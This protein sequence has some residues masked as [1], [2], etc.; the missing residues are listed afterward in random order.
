MRQFLEQYLSWSS[1][2]IHAQHVQK[3]QRF[4]DEGNKR[5]SDTFSL[6]C[7]V[8]AQQFQD[9]HTCEGLYK[10][11]LGEGRLPTPVFWPREFH[12]LYSQ[13]TGLQRVRHNL[14][15]FTFTFHKGCIRGY[16]SG[17]LEEIHIA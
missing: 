11:Y 15:T 1:K 2:H 6:V 8:V 7:P 10:G 12:G 4:Q 3:P 16:N 13:S 14:V 17:T 9:F 5:P